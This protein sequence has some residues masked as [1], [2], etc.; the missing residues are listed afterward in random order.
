MATHTTCDHCSTPVDK[1]LCANHA[2]VRCDVCERVSDRLMCESCA[3]DEYGDDDDYRDAKDEDVAALLEQSVIGDDVSDLAAAIRRGDLSEAEYMLDKI[4]SAV[5]S[6]S[7][8]VSLGRYSSRA[9][10]A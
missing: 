7:D 2:E 8:L 9:K 3:E 6:W 10:A 4:A 5:P 1:V